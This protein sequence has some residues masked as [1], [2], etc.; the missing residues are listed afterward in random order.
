M[1]RDESGGG[2]SNGATRSRFSLKGSAKLVSEFFG[3]Y[4][5]QFVSDMILTRVEDYSINSILFQRALYPPE[6]FKVV[7]KYGL[8]ILVSTDEEVKGYIKRVM[9]QLSQ[10]MRKGKISKLILAIVSKDSG[11]VVERWQFDVEIFGKMSASDLPD[12]SE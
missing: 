11:E 8:N 10:W 9:G 2:R 4:L 5:R 3:W 7:K 1:S 12:S 6:D